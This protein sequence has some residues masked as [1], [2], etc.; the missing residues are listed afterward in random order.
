MCNGDG[1]VR[2]WTGDEMEKTTCQDKGC[3]DD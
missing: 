3:H 2:E 1:I